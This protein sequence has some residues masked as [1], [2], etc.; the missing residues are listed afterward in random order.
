MYNFNRSFSFHF[1]ITDKCNARC[2]QCDRNYI[3]DKGELVEHPGMFLTEITIDQFKQIFKNY[4]KKTDSITFCGN[5]GDPVLAKDVFEMTEYTLTNVLYQDGYFQ[6]YTN[7]GFRSK[8]WWAEYGK[9]LKGKTH[10][11]HFAID[12]LEDTNHLYRVNTRYDRVIENAKAFIDAGGDAEWCFIRFGHNQHQEEEAKERAK[13]LKFKK[14]TAVNTPRF[15]NKEKIDYIWKGNNYSITRYKPKQK[16]NTAIEPTTLL[17]STM[18]N[19]FSADEINSNL[20]QNSNNYF[21]ANDLIS[22]A[23]YISC[24][25]QKYNDVFIDTMGYVYPCCWIGTY[26]YQ[27]MSKMDGPTQ[28]LLDN[29]KLVKAWDKD[30][31][32]ILKEDWFQNTLPN[33]W[34]NDPCHTCSKQCGKNK[35]MTIRQSKSI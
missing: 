19:K 15:K 24:H 12:G 23:G 29:R 16:T 18:F 28:S 21:K 10:L 32:E 8:E 2:P 14:F 20:Q 22:S 26:E 4:Q 1:E 9:M 31:I 25:T 6:N 33:S 11:I 3:N 5:M 27:K 30:F 13:K 17:R 34:D 35:I 7:G